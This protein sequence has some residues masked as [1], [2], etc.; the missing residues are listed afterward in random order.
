MKR[1][2]LLIAGFMVLLAASAHAQ[3]ADAILGNW[4]TEEKRAVVEIYP[5]DGRY[6]GK[7]AWLKEPKNEDGTDKLDTKNPDPSKRDRRA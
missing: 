7:V 2:P 6:C 1:L 3:K 5:C 4:F